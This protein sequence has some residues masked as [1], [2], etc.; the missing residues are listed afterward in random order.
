METIRKILAS[1]GIHPLE[2][3][4]VSDNVFRIEDAQQAYALKRSGLTKESIPLWENTLHQANA[5][6][7]NVLPVYLT[8][9]RSLAAEMDHT[10][11]YLT[12]WIQSEEPNIGLL[13]HSLGSIHAKTKQYHHFDQEKVEEQFHTYKNHCKA[14]QEKLFRYVE[15]YEKNRYMSPFEL[16]VCMQYR[17]LEYACGECLRL[18]DLFLEEQSQQTVWSY[19]LCHGNLQLSHVLHANSTYLINWEK[20]HYSNPLDDLVHLFAHDIG[21]Y[22]APE[23]SFID[24]FSV[25]MNENELTKTELYLL[26]IHLLDPT[27]YMTIVEN[28]EV[29]SETMVKKVQALQHAYRRVV[30]G[31]RWADYVRKTYDEIVLDDLED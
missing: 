20:A 5:Q 14:M 9:Q 11:Y 24:Q 12:P 16:L 7:L 28:C 8:R 4:K 31:L 21:T 6:N 17:D 19:S 1:Y 26:T 22:D 25:Y 29:A 18:I 15:Q 27:E 3:E 30:F 10:L 13:Y 23:K 2:I